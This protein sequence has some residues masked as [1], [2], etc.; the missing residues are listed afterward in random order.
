MLSWF[1]KYLKPSASY[2]GPTADAP[3]FEL[4]LS[5]GWKLEPTNDAEQY[6]FV[7]N[8]GSIITASY[9]NW[10]ISADRLPEAAEVLLKARGE[11]MGE[12]LGGYK[13]TI[14]DFQTIPVPYPGLEI[15]AAGGANAV[16]YFS[17][18]YALLTERFLVNLYVESPASS[19]EANQV[20]FEQVLHGL[21]I[22]WQE[23]GVKR[24]LRPTRLS[25]I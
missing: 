20:Q 12:G 18:Y 19:A 13:Y 2:D 10:D 16:S 6:S 5:R 1:T 11:A 8:D 15:Y 3:H 21:G 14:T 23:A 9:M 25:D 24:M 4:K 22:K 7:A 17:R